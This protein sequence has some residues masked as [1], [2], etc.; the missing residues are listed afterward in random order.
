MATRSTTARRLAI[1]VVATAA[2]SLTGAGASSAATE[3][4]AAP[5]ASQTQT[6]LL[7]GL[8]GTLNGVLGTD[9]LNLEKQGVAAPADQDKAL[10]GPVVGGLTDT[11][12]GLPVL[13][14]TVGDVT[15]T[16]GLSE[17]KQDAAAPAPAKPQAPAVKP[18][19]DKIDKAARN[20]QSS[21]M[22]STWTAPMT[23]SVPVAPAVAATENKPNPIVVVARDIASIFPSNASEVAAAGAGAATIALI[24]LGGIACTGAAGAASAAGRRGLISGSVGGSL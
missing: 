5:V 19:K 6:G 2:V 14:E 8:V 20:T 22:G 7:G 4:P 15:D 12:K 21:P 23:V 13:G 17:A 1:V 9:L 24:V 18:N 11:L 3:A 16:V 10:L